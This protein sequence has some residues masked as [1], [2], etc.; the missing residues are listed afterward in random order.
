M[1]ASIAQSIPHDGSALASRAA[2]TRYALRATF[3]MPFAAR[4]LMIFRVLGALFAESRWPVLIV[5]RQHE[6]P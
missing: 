5:H 6:G 1:P 4:P 3:G 2:A